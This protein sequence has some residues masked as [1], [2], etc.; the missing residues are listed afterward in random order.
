MHATLHH[1]KEQW[2]ILKAMYDTSQQRIQ[3]IMQR[4]TIKPSDMFMS[5]AVDDWLLIKVV[6]IMAIINTNDHWSAGTLHATAWMMLLMNNMIPVKFNIVY[7]NMIPAIENFFLILR[8]VVHCYYCILCDVLWPLAIS[9]VVSFFNKFMFV[10]FDQ[11]NIVWVFLMPLLLY[12]GV[13]LC[14]WWW[15]APGVPSRAR[16]RK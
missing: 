13:S 1:C 15:V 14:Q 12:F 9:I 7:H 8:F 6:T 11:Y 3:I 16:K 5:N 4:K 2:P 10:I